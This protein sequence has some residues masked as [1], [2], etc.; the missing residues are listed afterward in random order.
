IST[1]RIIVAENRVAGGGEPAPRRDWAERQMRGRVQ[2]APWAIVTY[3]SASERGGL[4]QLLKLAAEVREARRRRVP[5]PA[6]NAVL[7]K[8]VQEH[9]PPVVHSKRVK[10]LYATQAGIEPPTFILFVNDPKIVHF[11]YRR[12]LERVIRENYDF[13]GTAIKLVLKSRS[14]GDPGS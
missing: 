12:Y 14:E 2:F 11:S 10:L 8:A 4:P 6:L 9:V 13:E 7:K 3:I 5:T 1:A